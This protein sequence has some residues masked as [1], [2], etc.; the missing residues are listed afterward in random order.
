LGALRRKGYLN[1]LCVQALLKRNACLQ[2][3]SVVKLC[4]LCVY[5][6]EEEEKRR[7]QRN[8]KDDFVILVF[9]EKS[10]FASKKLL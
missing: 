7:F 4:S 10:F 9:I 2:I 3:A 5:V 8:E 6:K 1:I